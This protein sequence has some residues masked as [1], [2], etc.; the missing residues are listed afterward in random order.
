MLTGQRGGT[1]DAAQGRGG[2]QISSPDPMEE[3][4][5]TSRWEKEAKFWRKLAEKKEKENAELRRVLAETRTARREEAEAS[6]QEME[7]IAIDQ[8]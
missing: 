4:A 5:G 3:G 6:L 2:V 8:N 7:D 1:H